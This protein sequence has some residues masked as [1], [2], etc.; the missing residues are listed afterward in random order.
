MRKRILIF[1]LSLLITPG[2]FAQ[3]EKWT[4]LF[5]GKTLN[6]WKQLGGKAKYEVS[7]GE[8]VG[9]TVANTPNSFLC[10]EK[11]Y[12]NFIFEVELLVDNSMNSGIQFRSLSKPDYQNGRVHG[13]QMEVDPSDRAWSGGIYDEGRRDWLYIPNINPEGKKAFKKGQ[14]NKYRVEAIGNVIRTWINGIPVACL[15]DDVTAKGFIALQVHSIGKDQ[16]EGTPIRWKNI[17][18]Q[19][20]ADMKP[21]PADNT[22]VINLTLNTL[23]D[24]EKAQ[25][26]EFL[27]NGKDFTGWRGV[28]QDKMP[29]KHWKV[30]NGEINVSPS[31]GSETGNDIVTDKKFS[32]FELT[33]EFRLTEGANSGVKYFVNEAFDSGG[34]S[35]IGLEYQVLDDEKHPDAKL[36]AAGN[37]TMASLYDLIPSYKLDKRFQRKI[38]E[39]N[40]ARIIVYPNNIVQ[41]WLNGFKVVEYERGS[42]IF[43][44]LVARSKYKDFENFG[45]IEQGPILLQDHGNNVS[46]KNLKIRT[47]K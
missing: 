41:H 22:P 7:N 27:F 32:A 20:G 4:N 25:G 30:E 2:V 47:I 15:I 18:I 31:D 16:K 3:K 39:W 12:D 1:L 46:F 43:K 26:Y 21:H 8:I 6:G 34:K 44:A 36:G 42:N 40:Q 45:M 9:T 10:S 24:Q 33:F 14:W 13:Y 11:E 19:T 29:A 17:R 37:R 35:G 5:D 38:G 28:H 23:S